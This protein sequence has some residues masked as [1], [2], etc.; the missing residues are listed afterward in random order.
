MNYALEELQSGRR[1]CDYFHVESDES[2]SDSMS[3]AGHACGEREEIAAVTSNILTNDA[4]IIVFLDAETQEPSFQISSRGRK[5]DDTT[6]HTQLLAFL[7]ELQQVT[8]E[9]LPSNNLPIFTRHQRGD[10]IFHAHPNYRGKGAWK[11]WAV[12]DWGPGYGQ[13]PCHI[14]AFV[15][16]DNMPTGSNRLVFGGIQLKKRNIY[17]D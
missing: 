12:I 2:S 11:D 5:A 10:V 14:H 6:M 1:P 17:S 16:L 7:C 8:A 9:H 4:K 15:Q 3:H 13:L